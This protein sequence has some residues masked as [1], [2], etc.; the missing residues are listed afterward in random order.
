MRIAIVVDR[1]P[2]LSE[3]FVIKQVVELIKL[4]CEVNVL[5]MEI[6]NGKIQHKLVNE[7]DLM[8]NVQLISNIPSGANTYQKST[9]LLFSMLKNFVS[10]KYTNVAIKTLPMIKK[11][12]IWQALNINCACG[13]IVFKD[14]NHEY[15]FVIAHFGNNGVIASH[16]IEAGLISGKLIS[17]FHGFDLSRKSFLLKWGSL[18]KQ[19]FKTSDLLMPVSYHWKQ[20]LSELGA[21]DN[22]IRV[23]R[24][25]VD[26]GEFEYI[27]RR[28]LHNKLQVLT[29][30]RATEKKGI[31]YALKAVANC[32]FPIQYNII[33]DGPLLEDYKRLARE[34]N[35]CEKVNFL[36]SKPNEFV[37]QSLMDSDVFLLP[38][39]TAEDGDKEGIPVALMEAMALGVITISTYHSG[40]P[41]LISHAESGLLTKEKDSDSITNQL[42]DIFHKKIDRLYITNKARAKIN[43]E[44]NNEK[45]VKNLYDDMLNLR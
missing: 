7:Y 5:T 10:I 21:P 18:Y 25:G 30:G 38:S 45:I 8:K 16:L 33:G 22:K 36:G 14:K 12:L 11:K 40:I 9:R 41:E 13:N 43:N 39:V 32:N 26:V 2:A 1:F 28:H 37:R 24:M 27:P 20:Q 17:I 31:E 34:L 29:V 44:F 4:G 19:L 23:L 15:D 42:S 3:T 35:I 6:E